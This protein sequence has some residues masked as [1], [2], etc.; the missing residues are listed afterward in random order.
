[1]FSF[2]NRGLE[3]LISDNGI[4]FNTFEHATPGHYGL[5]MM[6]ERAATVGA[7]L[8][9]SSQPDQG[10]ELSLTWEEQEE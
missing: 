6:I 5:G 7:K 4:G 9:I 1:M 3:I 8:A 2:Q 10:T